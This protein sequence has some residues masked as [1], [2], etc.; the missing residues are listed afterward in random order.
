M[1][2]KLAT[3]A[4]AILLATPLMTGSTFAYPWSGIGTYL[5]L[6]LG[7]YVVR[8]F[9]NAFDNVALTRPQTVLSESHIIAE[10][11][12]ASCPAGQ[13]LSA[14]RQCVIIITVV[15]QPVITTQTQA[16]DLTTNPCPAYAS[17]LLADGQCAQVMVGGPDVQATGIGAVAVIQQE[18]STTGVCSTTTS[19]PTITVAPSLAALG[20]GSGLFGF[21][22]HP[23]IAFPH[24]HASTSNSTTGTGASASVSAS[25][26]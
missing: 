21:G 8:H 15:Q 6:G 18:A 19:A 4:V 12:V 26:C 3:L 16:D 17:T 20:L 5:R 10:P 24:F 14:A 11:S 25:A 22:V 13:V 7:A 23:F 9:D 1:Y 2:S